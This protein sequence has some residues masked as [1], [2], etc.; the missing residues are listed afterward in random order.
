[1][2]VLA[3]L[4]RII[5]V[6]AGPGDPELITVRGDRRLRRADVVVY[7]RLVDLRLL[8]RTPRGCEKICVGKKGG[9]YTFPQDKIN[10]LLVNRAAQGKQVVRL[11]GGDPFLLGRGG[12]EALYAARHGIP[13]E[14]VPGVSSAW[15]VPAAAGIPLTQRGLSS[16]VTILSGHQA[17][18]SEA[19]VDWAAI[20]AGSD[21]LV[22]LMPLGNLRHIV[23]QLVLHG[24]PLDTPA[25]MI[26]SAT[27]GNQAEAMGSLRNIVAET[28][29]VGI[30]SPALLV[31]GE[32][33]NLASRLSGL[34]RFF[35]KREPEA[36]HIRSS[37]SENF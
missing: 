34:K 5:L 3:P 6:G 31:V 25:A 24:K 10:E 13:C 21:T 27:L 17:S 9:H 26:Q 23:A 15:A 1:M 28:L 36:A 29:R 22:I 8:E 4:G 18:G 35:A 14:V 33:V 7:D 32:V 12:E 37:K 16:S 30:E 11:K 2:K 19:D 20:V